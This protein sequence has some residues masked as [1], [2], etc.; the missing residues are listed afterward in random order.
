MGVLRLSTLWLTVLFIQGC[1]P[2][3]PPDTTPPTKTVF[4]P[5]TQ[6][7]DKARGVQKTVDQQAQE[8]QKTIDAQERGDSA[9]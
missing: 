6:K 8:T 5:L 3:P 2:S 9:Q 4:D 1:S 7:M